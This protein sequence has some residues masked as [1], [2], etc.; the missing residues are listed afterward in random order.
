MSA[1]RVYSIFYIAPMMDSIRLFLETRFGGI[2][3]HSVIQRLFIAMLLLVAARLLLIFL[4][5]VIN[6]AENRGLDSSAKPLVYSLFSYCIYIVTL[7]LVLHVLGVNTAGIVAMVG[8]ASLAVGLA[9]KDALANIA[10]GLLLLFLRPFKA[11]DYIECGSIKGNIVGIGL[12]NTTLRTIDGL[13]VSSPNTSLWG[14]PIVNFSKNPLRRLEITV[15][16]DYGDSPEK[17]LDIMRDV[18]ATEPLFMR[19][20]EPQ[21]FVSGLED[22]AVNVTF[23]AWTRTQDYFNLR[24]KYTAEIKKRFDEEKITIP[25]PQRVVHFVDC[26]QGPV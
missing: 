21:F 15:G 13:Y 18:V 4:K 14:Q 17:A 23:R 9:L 24:W 11:G 19:K 6:Q 12:F 16:I 5:H 2:L 10:S 26:P 3:D 7:L 20:P 1:V 8:A 22:S 25:F